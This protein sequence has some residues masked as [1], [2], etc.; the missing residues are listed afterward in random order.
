MDPCKRSLS[1]AKQ[2]SRM[3]PVTGYP[4]LTTLLITF[5]L[6]MPSVL[7]A[8]DAIE[9]DDQWRFG[10]ELYGWLPKISGSTASGSDIDV[11]QSDLLDVLQMTLQGIVGVAKGKWSFTV[12]TVYLSVGDDQ[13]GFSS[14]SSGY[15]YAYTDVDL[16][17]WIVTSTVGYRVLDHEKGKLRIIAGA[18]YL[19]LDLDVDVDLAA[20]PPDSR[21]I[22]DSSSISDGILGVNGEI[23]LNEQWYL[24][25]YLDIGTGDSDLTWQAALS[26]GYR[27]SSF[28][29]IAGYRY[30]TWD[31][32]GHPALDDLTVNGPYA[33]IRFSF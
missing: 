11:G 27:F 19:S 31:L 26:V 29:L 8:E 12:D 24:P 7:M 33:G 18:R 13:E 14:G 1:G 3:S 28:D 22:S 25:F 10:V 21:N 30:L 23:T 20:F 16:Q 15:V 17:T 32:N 2:S 6:T 4:L 5:L 9:S